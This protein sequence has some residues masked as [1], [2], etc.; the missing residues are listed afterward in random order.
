[1]K[2]KRPLIAPALFAMSAIAHSAAAQEVPVYSTPQAALDALV[3]A[4]ESGDSL[5]VLDV[6]DP[7]AGDLLDAPDE[8]KQEFMKEFLTLFDEGWRFVRHEDGY[9]AIELGTEAWPFPIPLTAFDGGWIYDAEEGR[10]EINARKIGLNELAVIELLH[11]YHAAQTAYRSVDFDG[12][13]VR[14]FAAHLISTDGTKDGLYWPGEDSLVG[15]AAASASLDGVEGADH[16]P[17]LG[18]YYRILTSQ[19]PS[20]PGGAMDYE[21]NGHLLG[22]HALLAVPANYGASGTHTFIINEAGLI[23]EVDL[24]PESLDLAYSIRSFDPGSDWSKLDD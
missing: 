22:G 18:Y 14:E 6:M 3:Q 20:A 19:G 4:M 2:S 12:D 1:M 24:G 5:S 16:T 23:W 10:A 7:G 21:I 8:T 17:L 9:V 15:P 13:G 11:G